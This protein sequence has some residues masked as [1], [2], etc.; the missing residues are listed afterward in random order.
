MSKRVPGSHRTREALREL[1]EG[2]Y[3]GSFGCT[4]LVQLATRLIIEE[5]LEEMKGETE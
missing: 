1:M 5:S 4:E 2:R 3:S